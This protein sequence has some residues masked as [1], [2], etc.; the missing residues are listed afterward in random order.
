MRIEHGD[1]IVLEG[2][3]RGSFLVS[4]AKW[5]D[6]LMRITLSPNHSMLL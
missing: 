1:A 5:A 4:V 2:I 3:V 6:T